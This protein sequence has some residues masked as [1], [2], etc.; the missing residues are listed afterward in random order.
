MQRHRTDYWLWGLL[1]VGMRVAFVAVDY[2]VGDHIFGG[3]L[4]RLLPDRPAGTLTIDVCNALCMVVPAAAVGWLVQALA[5]LCGVRLT[6][7]AA[8][9]QTTDYDDPP[10]AD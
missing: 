1:S 4:A 7:R 8:P 3:R 5:V 10:A 2:W 6:D 9:P